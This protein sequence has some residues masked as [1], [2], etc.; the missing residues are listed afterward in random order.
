MGIAD[1]LDKKWVVPTAVGVSAAAGGFVAGY[2]Y[3]KKKGVDEFMNDVQDFV[4]VDTADDIG[5]N[6]QQDIFRDY[7]PSGV[8]ANLEDVDFDAQLKLEQAIRDVNLEE[9]LAELKVL[10]P[11]DDEVVVDY[12]SVNPAVGDILEKVGELPVTPVIHNIFEGT[13]EWDFEEELKRRAFNMPYI[14]HVDEFIQ[15][16]SEFQQETLTYYAG[17][18][19]LADQLET[20]IYNYSE[21]MGALR[22]GHGSNDPNV[23]YIRN[24]KIKMEW[25]IIRHTGMFA[26]EVRGL[27]IEQSYEEQDNKTEPRKMRQEG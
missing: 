7:D 9:R 20:P 26:I 5:P 3:G 19:V 4:D 23:V 10:R 17:D 16:E 14:L 13:T 22:F 12:S 24:E 21:L 1:I 18:D 15:N 6:Y 25:E 11:E 2:I 27:E 8:Y